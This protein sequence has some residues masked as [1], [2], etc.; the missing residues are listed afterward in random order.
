MTDT[1]RVLRTFRD[2]YRHASWNGR[3]YFVLGRRILRH[4]GVAPRVWR[5]DLWGFLFDD[6]DGLLRGCYAWDPDIMGSYPDLLRTL[7]NNLCVFLTPFYRPR[8]SL[9]AAVYNYNDTK[10]L[11]YD[12]KFVRIRNRREDCVYVEVTC[13]WFTATATRIRFV[14]KDG[15][16]VCAFVTGTEG[17]T[18]EETVLAKGPC[19]TWAQC[20]LLFDRI[21]WASPE[22]DWIDSKETK[23]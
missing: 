22:L 19:L 1:P 6:F 2:G 21:R 8:R 23:T 14:G 17:T 18:K 16:G 3:H 12:R 4:Q 11:T 9:L 20:D 15:K 7:W 10:L 13:G 5:F